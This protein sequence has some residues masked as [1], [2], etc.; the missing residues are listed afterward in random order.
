MLGRVTQGTMT[1][2]LLGNI[3]KNLKKAADLQEKMGTGR[4]INR[5]SDDPVGIT[6]SLRYRSELSINT[7][8]QTNVDSALSWLDFCDTIL[9]QA[10]DVL[11]RVKELAVQ[12]ANGTNPQVALDN[13]A[14]EMEQMKDQM[15]DIANSQFR[16]KYVFGG[17]QTDQKPYPS[18]VDPKEVLTDQ[19][20]LDYIINTGIKLTVNLIGNDV[21]GYPPASTGVVV[22]PPNSNED[23]NVFN[24]L[25][26]IISNLRNGNHAGV[27]AQIP[28]LESRMD[29]ILTQ[30]A[31]VGARVNRIELMEQRLKDL[32][33][34]LVTLQSKTEDADLE[35]LIIKSKVN[36]NVYQ[37]SL[38]VGAKI[39]MPTLV[40]FLR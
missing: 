20:T 22:N 26:E 23:D 6:Y 40:D 5:P 31:E 19:G 34:N 21:F 32:N 38:A 18:G 36:E 14:G 29:K 10:V 15:L 27:S 9:S 16:G 25:D 2:Q 33:L 30:R 39:I 3:N 11:K 35:E 17:Q 1:A 12:G 7:R 37:A 8:F 28:L 24:V 13:I 4:K